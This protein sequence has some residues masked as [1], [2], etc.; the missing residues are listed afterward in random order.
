[1]T[2]LVMFE[3]ESRGP[4]QIIHLIV[5]LLLLEALGGEGYGIL[6]YADCH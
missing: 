3:Q 1:M 6:E 4:L 5:L 2:Q